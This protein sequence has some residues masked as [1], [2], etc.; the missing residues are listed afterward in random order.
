MS[1]FD[2]AWDL[3]KFKDW[4]SEGD[5]FEAPPPE[6][7]PVNPTE[8]FA[9]EM[10]LEYPIVHI[11]PEGAGFFLGYQCGDYATTGRLLGGMDGVNARFV[12]ESFGQAHLQRCERCQSALHDPRNLDLSARQRRNLQ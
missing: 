5:P 8:D 3:L 7:P 2:R 1:P 6:K 9:R 4:E 10:G 11:E 12:N